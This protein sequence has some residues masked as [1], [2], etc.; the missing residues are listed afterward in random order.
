MIEGN[1][2]FVFPFFISWE[3][4]NGL[5]NLPIVPLREKPEHQ[6]QQVSQLLFGEG[7]QVLEKQDQWQKIQTENDSYIGWMQLSQGI[8]VEADFYKA[9]LQKDVQLTHEPVTVI[10]RNDN[11]SLLHLPAGCRLAGVA[12]D[13]F[14]VGEITFE[15]LHSVAFKKNKLIKYANNFLNTPYLWGGRTH[16]GI[17]CSGFAQIVYRL[18]GF[19]LKRDAWQQAEQGEPVDFL[20]HTLPGDLA[21]FD[22]DEG[23]IV[24]VGIM[25]DAERIIHA[26]GYVK[27]DRIDTKGIYDVAQKKYTHQLRIIK[28]YF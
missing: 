20:Q 13:K 21:F 23:R 15:L 25:L 27:I 14:T 12:E 4:Q 24:H 16:F 10:R 9:Y 22:N 11:Y 1:T 18:H 8:L 26:S 7:F 19:Q 3:M 17:D 2:S 6:S 28:R 5:I